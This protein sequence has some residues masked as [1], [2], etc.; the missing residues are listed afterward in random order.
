[1]HIFPNDK[2]YIGIA[3]YERLHKRWGS[4]GCGYINNRQPIIERA[5][6]KYGWENIEH[7][8]LEKNL[9]KEESKKRE[10]Y[11]IKK[12][13]TFGING[14]NS[15]LGGDDNPNMLGDK[16]PSARKVVYKGKIYSTL[17]EFCNEFDLKMSTVS[18]WLHGHS[19]MPLNF[20]EGQLH[21]ENE[22]M[23]NIYKQVGRRKGSENGNAKTIIFYD[24]E[25]GTLN[26]FCEKYNVDRNRVK[27]WVSGRQPMP[28]FFYDGKL[29]YKGEDFSIVI[30]KN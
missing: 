11:Y 2:K 17:K 21:Y 23:S 30:C 8:I 29:H 12:Y 15:T 14:Y 5:I 25:F 13:D 27:A 16:N 24:K 1:M 4:N 20:Y 7:K 10:K 26:E 28:S 22:D 18:S 19:G 9:T 6:N 3:K